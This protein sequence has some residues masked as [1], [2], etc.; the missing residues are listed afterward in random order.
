M[1]QIADIGQ[2]CNEWFIRG[3]ETAVVREAEAQTNFRIVYPAP[4]TVIALDPDIPLEQQKVFFEAAPE[5]NTL[6][7]SLDGQP[8]G[9]AGAVLLW[10]PQSG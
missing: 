10:T 6:Q 4:E 9:L 8:A 7:W 5:G 1:V 3:T 2:M